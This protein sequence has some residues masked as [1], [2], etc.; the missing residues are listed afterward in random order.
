MYNVKLTYD[1]LI[2]VQIRLSFSDRIQRG[3]L[4]STHT[5]LQSG[6]VLCHHE[7]LAQICIAQHG[8]G[9]TILNVLAHSFLGQLHAF[10]DSRCGFCPLFV[11][12]FLAEDDREATKGK[13][14]AFLKK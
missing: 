1:S 3:L 2:V 14:V 4:I 13:S 8:P 12:A 9:H 5:Q 11:A 10:Q 7:E 6:W